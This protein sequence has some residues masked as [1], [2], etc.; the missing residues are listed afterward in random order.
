MEYHQTT[1]M[2]KPVLTL[3]AAWAAFDGLVFD[4]AEKV[5][6]RRVFY[7]GAQPILGILLAGLDPTV[8]VTEREVDRV[9]ALSS[10]LR[11][12]GEDVRGRLGVNA[13]KLDE[14]TGPAARTGR[15]TLRPTRHQCATLHAGG[16][17]SLDGAPVCAG[18]L[19]D[20]ESNLR[21]SR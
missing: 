13:P 4:D 11:R 5:A 17:A 10:E 14:L 2:P 3:A 1:P 18:S 6:V 7:A 12:F 16:F 19:T 21:N 9:E 8:E 20:S 15:L